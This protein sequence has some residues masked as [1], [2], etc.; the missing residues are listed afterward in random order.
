[1]RMSKLK[2]IDLRELLNEVVDG[3]SKNKSK[4]AIEYSLERFNGDY[5]QLLYDYY[6][7]AHRTHESSY[8][9]FYEMMRLNDEEDYQ[10]IKSRITAFYE[11]MRLNDE[12]DYQYIKSLG[13]K[14][15]K[16]PYDYNLKP[17]PI[18]Q[19]DTRFGMEVSNGFYTRWSYLF[20]M[21][22]YIEAQCYEVYDFDYGL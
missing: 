15:Y 11:M 9:A 10:Y 3:L 12:E 19:R 7:R 17:Y 13:A 18:K 2:R 4:I 8:P 14:R 5:N 20:D 21:Y 6:Q 22:Q 1:M 16:K